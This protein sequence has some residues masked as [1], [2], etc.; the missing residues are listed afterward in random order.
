MLDNAVWTYQIDIKKAV[1]EKTENPCE[2]ANVDVLKKF[3]E[4]AKTATTLFYFKIF[5]DIINPFL[6][7]LVLKPC[8]K[9][10]EPLSDMIP[11]T[12]KQFIDPAEMFDKLVKGIV[13]DTIKTIIEG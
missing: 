5:S 12:M 8:N 6:N 3:E 7:K 13:D 2:S 11:D 4:D 9:I 10:I 1:E